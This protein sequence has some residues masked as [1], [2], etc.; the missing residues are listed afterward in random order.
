MN[1]NVTQ[2]LTVYTCLIKRIR[3]VMHTFFPSMKKTILLRD[4]KFCWI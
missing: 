1:F 4:L 3:S 2:R